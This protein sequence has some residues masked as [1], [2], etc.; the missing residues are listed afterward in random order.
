[1]VFDSLVQVFGGLALFLYGLRCLS[2]SLEQLA[3]SNLQRMLERLTDNPLKGSVFGAFATALLQSS[4]LLMVTLIGLLNANLLS[5]NQ[6]VGI[7]LGMEIGTTMTAQLVSFNIGKL[8]LHLIAVGFFTTFLLKRERIRLVGQAVLGLGL[9]FMGMQFMSSGAKAL[10]E[11]PD[12]YAVISTLNQNIYLGLVFGAVFTAVIQSS[13]AMTGLVIALGSA[14]TIGLPFA[15]AL[16]FGANIGTCITGVL[17]ALESKLSAKRASAAQVF[18]NVFGV[19]LFLPFLNPFAALVAGTSPL[20]PRQIA[21]AHTIFNIIVTLIML[22]LIRVLVKAITA[23]MPGEVESILGNVRYIEDRLLNM[24]PLALHNSEREV[25]RLGDISLKMLEDAGEGVLNRDAV[26]AESALQKEDAIDDITLKI[27]LFLDKI[28]VKTNN[29]EELNLVNTLRNSIID[30]ERVGDLAENIAEAGQEMIELNIKLTEREHADLEKLV[31]KVLES[32]STSLKSL[33]TKEL[34]VAE[35]VLELEDEV[36]M[37]ERQI[38]VDYT[39]KKDEARNPYLH[40]LYVEMLRDLERIGDH[41][42]NI[43]DNIIDRE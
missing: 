37:L 28:A 38:R 31:D 25:H 40:T 19:L 6:A 18:I 12:V 9:L 33:K 21:N 22:P 42:N 7:I 34:S 30:M 39:K 36:D 29:N 43:A 10:T 32:Y 1:M 11:S 24:I 15:I 20:L 4:S 41:A 26:K 13:S 5:L 23:V 27:Q 2:G 8:Y 16:I 35:K 17:A 14:G 3:S